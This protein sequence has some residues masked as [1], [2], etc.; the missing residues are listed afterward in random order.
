MPIV[1]MSAC[2]GVCAASAQDVLAAWAASSGMHSRHRTRLPCSIRAA[3]ARAC[4]WRCSGAS[5]DS[6]CHGVGVM[7]SGCLCDG[8][9]DLSSCGTLSDADLKCGRS[10]MHTCIHAHLHTHHA[11]HIAWTFC[12]LA[13]CGSS[14]HTPPWVRTAFV[15]NVSRAPLER[16]G[17]SIRDRAACCR[18][19]PVLLDRAPAAQCT[20]CSI[21]ARYAA[22]CNKSAA[23]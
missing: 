19:C 8:R 23:P 3:A 16:R 10:Y 20:C 13:A 9:V 22:N 18:P 4:G 14:A 15:V 7:S 21:G 6:L 1:R 17:S 5:R 2:G 12:L 11:A